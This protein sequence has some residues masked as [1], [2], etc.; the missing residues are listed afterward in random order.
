MHELV[1]MLAAAGKC[2]LLLLLADAQQ[3][4]QQQQQQQPW[5]FTVLSG[6]IDL[7]IRLFF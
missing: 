7:T 1:C 5:N 2:S 4:Q 3:Q 6:K